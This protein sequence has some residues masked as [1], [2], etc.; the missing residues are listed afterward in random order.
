[1]KA[2]TCAVTVLTAFSAAGALAADC[3]PTQPTTEGTHYVA[4]AP[5]RGDVGNEIRVH[6]KVMAAGSCKPIGGARIESWQSGREGIY[7]D[8]LR[9]HRFA[10]EDGS[11]AYGTEWPGTPTPHIHFKVSAPGYRPLT[12]MWLGNPDIE[13]KDIRFDFVLIPE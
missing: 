12:T 4:G 5:E 9:S 2:S 11:Y 10:K 1:M 8:R 6:G 13:P 7:V 3:E